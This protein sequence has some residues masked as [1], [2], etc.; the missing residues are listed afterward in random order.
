MVA[1][2]LMPLSLLSGRQHYQ[3]TMKAGSIDVAA[4]HMV[5]EKLLHFSLN[6]ATLLLESPVIQLSLLHK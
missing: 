5:A 4:Q 1:E 3:F 2:K 6:Q